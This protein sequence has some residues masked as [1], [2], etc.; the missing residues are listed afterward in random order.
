MAGA[1][2][3]IGFND[4]P[5]VLSA[6]EA[7]VMPRDAKPLLRSMSVYLSARAKRS[8]ASATDPDGRAWKPVIPGL[9]PRGGAAPLRDRGLLMA[10]ASAGAS[11]GGPGAI[12]TLTDTHLEQGT[13]IEYAAIHQYGGEI[14]PKSGRALAIPV[15][16]EAYGKRPR[17]FG[18][19]LAVVW[20][21]G[22]RSGWLVERRAGRHAKT[23]FHY[24]LVSKVTIPARPFLGISDKDADK[25][26]MMAADF[27]SGGT[28]G[29]GAAGGN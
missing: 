16:R 11:G 19:P 9:R 22:K 27:F 24:L 6:A 5:A 23:I 15:S 29:S 10:S 21:K 20:P 1:A 7:E 28:G 14:R 18:K 17:A 13:N 4:L 8:F 3:I 26:A 25:L 2:T 12:F